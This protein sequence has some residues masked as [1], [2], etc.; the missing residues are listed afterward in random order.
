[1]NYQE[2]KHLAEAW[3]IDHDTSL[4]GW[5]S[6]IAVLLQ[7]IKHLEANNADLHLH[8]K[9]V[10]EENDK[11]AIDLGIKNNDFRLPSQPQ[12]QTIADI[13]R[14]CEGRN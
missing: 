8:I 11:L 6:V 1:M 10:H 4:D 7:R 5:R 3:T 14:E 9:R 2:A 12:L 13:I